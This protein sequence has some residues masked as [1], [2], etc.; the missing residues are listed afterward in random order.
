[1]TDV[2]RQAGPTRQRGCVPVRGE[3]KWAA[4]L[5]PSLGRGVPKAF[6]Y[7]FFFSSFLFFF[8]YL[9]ITFAFVVQKTSNQFV[10]FSKIPSNSPE[11]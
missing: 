10:N 9:F 2:A 6:L 7:I 11:L 4:G 8:L 5:F 3:G 1:M